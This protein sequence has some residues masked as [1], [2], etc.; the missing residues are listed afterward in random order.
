M[1][2]G[3]G[4][5][6]LADYQDEPAQMDSGCVGKKAYLNLVFAQQGECSILAKM[7]RRGS[8]LAQKALYWDRD[9]PGLPCVMMISTSGCIVQGDRLM[10]HVKVEEGACGHV[11]S[12]S[13][14]KI[15]LMNANY[16][17][18][19]QC[20]E[21]E[22]AGYLEFVPE[23]IIPHRH[24]RF[25]SETVLRCHPEGTLL[26]SE[27]LMSGRKYHHQ[28][29]R[30]GF[31]VYSST[32]KVLNADGDE[33]MA[34]RYVL[35]PSKESLD[36]IGVMQQFDIFANIIL[37][38]SKENQDRIISEINPLFDY[39]NKIA[40]GVSRLPNG[41]G[42]VFKVLTNDSGQAKDEVRQFWKL[43]REVCQGVSLTIPYFARQ[44]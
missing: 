10:L 26:Y 33:C 30:F 6:E 28:D 17:A 25:I 3:C 21:V 34:E 19:V 37:L 5:P 44:K 20:L 9:M 40:K 22:R 32:V 35:T 16:A 27:I 24:S 29:E 13:A 14:T 18:Q 8:Y 23:Q 4:A 31:D 7:E 42:V 11:T 43:A 15:N 38:T 39:K 36:D 1:Q 12:Q 41:V 2:L